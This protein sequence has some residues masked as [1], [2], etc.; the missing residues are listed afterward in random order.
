MLC[1]QTKQVSFITRRSSSARLAQLRIPSY[2][3]APTGQSK[4][5]VS[6]EEITFL[7]VAGRCQ[8]WS[9]PAQ[10][11]GKWKQS[12]PWCFSCAAKVHRVEQGGEHSGEERKGEELKTL[13]S[14]VQ[15]RKR[16]GG[17]GHR[18]ERGE[19]RGTQDIRRYSGVRKRK[20]K[21]GRV[22][23]VERGS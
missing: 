10:I 11:L 3:W 15:K 8:L 20:R 13:Y 5:L 7:S 9:L 12:W 6:R 22:Q 18:V 17:R 16:K 2:T 19:G 14:G 23:R 21:G 4:S 1:N